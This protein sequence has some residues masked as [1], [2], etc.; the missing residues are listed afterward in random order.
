MTVCVVRTFRKT[1]KRHLTYLCSDEEDF[2]ADMMHTGHN[3][4]ESNARE[5]VGVVTL[6]GI[7]C[8]AIE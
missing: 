4:P 6:T 8:L 7:V 2:F 3:C 1:G 5:D